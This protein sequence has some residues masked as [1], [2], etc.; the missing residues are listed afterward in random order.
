MGCQRTRDALKGR[1][2]LKKM[3]SRYPKCTATQTTQ[4]RHSKAKSAN[5][6]K[7]FARHGPCRNSWAPA[8]IVS[9]RPAA[10][11]VCRNSGK[12]KSVA[13]FTVKSG[14]IRTLRTF[15]SGNQ[16]AKYTIVQMVLQRCVR[17]SVLRLQPENFVAFFFPGPPGLSYPCAISIP[18][19]QSFAAFLQDRLIVLAYPGFQVLL[20]AHGPHLG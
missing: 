5:S 12:R 4:N 13:G 15:K 2:L 7:S 20:V 16:P 1:L 19:R 17:S 14:G 18:G 3:S 11:K 10:A 6:S 8:P 9:R